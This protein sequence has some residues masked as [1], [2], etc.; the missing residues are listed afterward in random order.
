MTLAICGLHFTA[1]AAVSLTPDPTVAKP[2]QLFDPQWLGSRSPSGPESR[3]RRS[4][5]RHPRP[6]S[7]DRSSREAARLR[8]YVAELEKTKKE[9]E[10]TTF[11]LK[12][13]LQLADEANKAKTM[14]LANMSYEL[15][16][17]LNAIIGFSELLIH[18]GFGELGDP[19]YRDY[20]QD[21]HDSGQH[22]LGLINDVLDISKLDA[23]VIETYQEPA[24]IPD[25]LHK[26]CRRCG[27]KP[28]APASRWSRR[29]IPRCR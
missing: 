27:R 10:Q 25:L 18:Q 12:R 21:I 28:S 26:T 20:A 29:S 1:M 7:R 14:F 16:T 22:L 24:S 11:E 19:H 2:Q 5:Q 13:A 15:R 9:L 17:P 6:A 23:V 8:H 4:R 3:H